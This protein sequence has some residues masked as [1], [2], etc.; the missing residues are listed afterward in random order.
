MTVVRKARGTYYILQ[1]QR[2]LLRSDE[3]AL[4]QELVFALCTKRRLLLHGLKDDYSRTSVSC[5]AMYALHRTLD[6][7]RLSWFDSARIWS[8]AVQLIT[9]SQRSSTNWKTHS[10]AP[11][12]Q[13][14]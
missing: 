7:N 1:W 11:W 10:I 8:Y 9:A 6:F 3:R 2:L 5:D 4:N 13:S 12:E 14:S